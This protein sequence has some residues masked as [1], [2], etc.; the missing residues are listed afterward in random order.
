MRQDGRAEEDEDAE[1]IVDGQKRGN[2]AP[3]ACD[4][5]HRRPQPRQVCGQAGCKPWAARFRF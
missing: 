1:F 4:R 5:A 3:A 2:G